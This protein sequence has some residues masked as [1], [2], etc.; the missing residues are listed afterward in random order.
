MNNYILLV[1]QPEG[2]INYVKVMNNSSYAEAEKYYMANKINDLEEELETAWERNEK[3]EKLKCK[4][5]I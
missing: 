5:R 2:I 4:K 3:K 1:L